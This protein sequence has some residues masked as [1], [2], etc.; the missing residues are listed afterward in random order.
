[1]ASCH[2][3]LSRQAWDFQSLVNL[4]KVTLCCNSLT[5]IQ[6]LQFLSPLSAITHALQ[7]F[8]LSSWSILGWISCTNPAHHHLKHR[9]FY[10]CFVCPTS[11]SQEKV[12]IKWFHEEKNQHNIGSKYSDQGRNS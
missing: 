4:C 12:A 9:C 8:P 10:L 1:M 6:L 7:L 5:F 2:C 3:V 11:A